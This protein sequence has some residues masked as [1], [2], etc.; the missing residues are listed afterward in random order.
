MCIFLGEKRDFLVDLSLCVYL[1]YVVRTYVTLKGKRKFYF[2]VF[3]LE[4]NKSYHIII[5]LY[6]KTI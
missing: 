1:R 3:I 5:K 2:A 6:L 4:N